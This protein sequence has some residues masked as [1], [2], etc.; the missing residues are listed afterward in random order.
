MKKIVITH[1]DIREDFIKD[2]DSL[3]KFISRNRRSK[4]KGGKFEKTHPPFK[5]VSKTFLRNALGQFY[6][7]VNGYLFV[8]DSWF[9]K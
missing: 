2:A 3:F 8:V 9:K 1:V 7:V 6:W 5:F 4:A